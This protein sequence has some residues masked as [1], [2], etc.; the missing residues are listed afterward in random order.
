MNRSF[1][2][3]TSWAR[4]TITFPVDTTGALGDDTTNDLE[5][6]FILHAGSNFT[7]VQQT[8]AFF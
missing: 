7:K 8:L 3:T 4:Q 5:L 2:V 1:P 6:R